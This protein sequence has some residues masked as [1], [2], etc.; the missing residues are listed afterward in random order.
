MK[1]FLRAIAAI[2]LVV[3]AMAAQAQL[4]LQVNSPVAGTVGNETFIGESTNVSFIVRQATRAVKVQAVVKYLPPVGP[5][6]TI[7]TVRKENLNPNQDNQVS[8]SLSVRL[9]R[10]VAP[11]GKYEIDVTA[12]YQDNAE[13]TTTTI[14]NLI[15][16]YTKPKILQFNPTDGSAVNGTKEIKV[17]IQEANLKEWRV[18]VNGNDIPDNTGTTVNPDGTFTVSWNPAGIENDGPQTITIR[19]TD[20]A[21]NEETRTAS[22]RL[23]RVKP[24]VTIAFPLSTSSIRPRSDFS[25]LVDVNDAGGVDVT[26]ID[27]TL[28]RTDGSFLYRVPRTNYAGTGGNTSRWS[29]RVKG[30]RVNLPTTFRV[31]VRV[32]DRAGNV[33]NQQTVTVTLR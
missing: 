25:V 27:V 29:G 33:A 14:N 32:V 20:K 1:N 3:S 5:A 31:Q 10:G 16:D 18:Q 30:S 9:Q 11:E 8:D 19:V 23:D 13:P 22:V 17:R 28:V 6:Q 12:S 15:V 4:T 7:T 2:T 26:G 24:V 21:N